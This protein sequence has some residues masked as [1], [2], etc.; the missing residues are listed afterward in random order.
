M[1]AEST[2]AFCSSCIVL[3]GEKV[4]DPDAAEP[5]VKN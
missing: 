5:A 4:T 1:G 2:V 3:D